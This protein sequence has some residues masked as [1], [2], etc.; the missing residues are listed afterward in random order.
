[1]NELKKILVCALGL[2][3]VF[4]MGCDVEECDEA[5]VCGDAGEGGA[6]G[7]VGGAGG[8]GGEGGGAPLVFDTVIIFDDG[9]PDDG[10][11][12]TGVDICGV[13]ADCAQA[14]SASATRGEGSVC[15]AEGPGCST[16]R[17]DAQAALDDGSAC[18]PGSVPS[19]YISLGTDGQLAVGFDGSIA[20]CSVTVVEFAGATAEAY[21]VFVCNDSDVANATCVNNDEPVFEAAAGGEA[22]FD[23]PAE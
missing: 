16:N 20:G 18:E 17:G 14:V 19:D 10:Q 8:V 4:A 6:G 1:M 12:T 2:T 3:V 22:T 23:V 9:S 11:G 5:G 7:D 15:E 21:S 13:S